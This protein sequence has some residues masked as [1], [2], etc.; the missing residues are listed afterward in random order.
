M[1]ILVPPSSLS[2]YLLFF[3]IKIVDI[4]SQVCQ[5]VS[6]KYFQSNHHIDQDW[7]VICLAPLEFVRNKAVDFMIFPHALE[8]HLLRTNRAEI[9]KTFKHHHAQLKVTGAY[10]KSVQ[11]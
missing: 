11:S 8:K 10:K 9:W 4:F 3:V 7:K 5:T 1:P 2:C 6:S